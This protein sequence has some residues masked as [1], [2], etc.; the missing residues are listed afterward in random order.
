[1]SSIANFKVRSLLLVDNPLGSYPPS[2]E[3]RDGSL[4][5]Q[6]VVTTN[7]EERLAKEWVCMQVALGMR[8]SELFCQVGP[9]NG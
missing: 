4:P 9:C 6:L 7:P 2:A 5:G 1:M 8:Q 3:E